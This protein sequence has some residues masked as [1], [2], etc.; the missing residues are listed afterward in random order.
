MK[1]FV[2]RE[3][4]FEWPRTS[5]ILRLIFSNTRFVV[6]WSSASSGRLMN[7]WNGFSSSYN[8]CHWRK[9]RLVLMACVVILNQS[10]PFCKRLS[11]VSLKALGRQARSIIPHDSQRWVFKIK[12]LSLPVRSVSSYCSVQI[13]LAMCSLTQSPAAQALLIRIKYCR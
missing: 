8:F 11:P 4:S 13:L 10:Q 2:S 1:P 7:I 12:L 5:W 3:K 6:R 9:L